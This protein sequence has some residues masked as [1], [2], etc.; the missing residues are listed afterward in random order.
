MNVMLPCN[1]PDG[2]YLVLQGN[3]TRL[4]NVAMK[5]V[6]HDVCTASEVRDTVAECEAAEH[7]TE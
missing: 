7:A 5:D 6:E 2:V 1:L 4:N 3:M